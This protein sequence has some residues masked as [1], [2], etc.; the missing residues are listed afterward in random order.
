M[1]HHRR[2]RHTQPLPQG[3]T[4]TTDRADRQSTCSVVLRFSVTTAINEHK[5]EHFRVRVD[6]PSYRVRGVRD[7]SLR[8]NTHNA[9]C[10]S[11]MWTTCDPHVPGVQANEQMNKQRRKIFISRRPVKPIEVHAMNVRFV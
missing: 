5:H 7:L 4:D 1:A 2:L 8:N 11:S 6:S 10:E 3:T 9:R